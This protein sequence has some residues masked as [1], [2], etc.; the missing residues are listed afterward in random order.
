M[1]ALIKWFV[2]WELLACHEP[3]PHIPINT[4]ALCMMGMWLEW[5]QL[6]LVVQGTKSFC[7]NVPKGI[8]I[9]CHKRWY[10]GDSWHIL[11]CCKVKTTNRPDSVG[12]I[13][14]MYLY[15]GHRMWNFYQYSMSCIALCY[16]FHTLFLSLKE[17]KNG[18]LYVEYCQY[19]IR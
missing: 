8:M 14:Q 9:T 7:R 16:K 19:V 6:D 18:S 12:T 2:T 17:N 3:S 5:V 15:F 11:E 4:H 13:M 1:A 10:W